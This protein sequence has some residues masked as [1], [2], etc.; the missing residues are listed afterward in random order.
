[1]GKQKRSEYLIT[2]ARYK[3]IK[4]FDHRQMENFCADIYKS[5]YEDGRASVP[6]VDVETIMEAIRSVKGIGAKRLYA[7]RDSIEAT[8]KGA[9]EDKK[10]GIRWI[11]N[12][13][14]K[15]LLRRIFILTIWHCRR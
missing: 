7:I 14:Q 6:G 11:L 5:G 9:G 10:G 8:F 12:R 2:R 13:E 4:A 15:R 3:S 1:M